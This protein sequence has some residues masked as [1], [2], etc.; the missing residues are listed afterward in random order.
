[1]AFLLDLAL[2]LAVLYCGW[3]GFR[4]GIINGICSILAVIVAIYGANLVATAYSSEFTGVM[5]PFATGLVESIESDLADYA[6]GTAD[7]DVEP[8]LPLSVTELDDDVLLSRS[9]LREL[10]FLEEVAAA[11]AERVPVVR[12]ERS[13]SQVEAVT[14]VICDRICF[15]LIFAIAYLLITLVFS[16]IG[17][18]LDVTFGIPG[19]ENINHITGAVLGVAQG[20]M[21][22]IV[23]TCLVRYLGILIP[24]TLLERTWITEKLVEGNKLASLLGL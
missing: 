14:E 17:N 7:E 16:V 8:K 2:V 19:H 1:M 22:V 13:L 6:A 23:L 5:K 11:M 10:G 9:V 18:V 4:T 15:V 3:R 20:V 12:E 21:L 24:D